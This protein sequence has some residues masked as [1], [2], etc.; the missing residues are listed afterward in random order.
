MLF[1]LLLIAKTQKCEQHDNQEACTR[2]I[3]SIFLIFARVNTK[4]MRHL[5][6]LILLL[7]AAVGTACS[8]NQAAAGEAEDIVASRTKNLTKTINY[9]HRPVAKRDIDVVVIHST[10]YLGPDSFNIDGVLKQFKRYDVCS[11]YIVGRDGIIYKTVAEN[12]VA[13]HAGVS[14][15]PGT[16]RKNC[17]SFSIGIEVICSPS[18]GP[19]DEQ[20]NSLVALVKD[21]KT[22]YTIN[23]VVRHSDI[24]PGRKTDPWRFDWKGFNQRLKEE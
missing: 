14:T 7:A 17:N 16:N 4:P 15:L 6:V 21:I 3:S 10:Y 19:T 12:N 20:Y 13:Y 1:H 9:G 18:Q 11:H 5:S 8:Q 24:A 22:R 2:S 23:Y